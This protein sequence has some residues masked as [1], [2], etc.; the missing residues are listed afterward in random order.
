MNRLTMLHLLVPLA[1]VLF[2]VAAPTAQAQTVVYHPPVVSYYYAPPTV[3]VPSVSYTP[4]YTSY[5]YAPVYSP[6]VYS[7]SYEIR[8]RPLRPWVYTVR[9]VTRV[10]YPSV[11]YYYAPVIVP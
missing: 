9:P 11:S 3:V 5:Y 6:P 8:Q 1:L 4:V 2:L 10:Y 7:T